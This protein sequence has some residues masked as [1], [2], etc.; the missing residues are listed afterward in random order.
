MTDA[1]PQ[2]SPANGS[3]GQGAV[4]LS[5]LPAGP[6]ERRLALGVALAS[7]AFFLLVAPFAR[8]QLGQVWA[9]IPMYESAAAMCDLITAALLLGQFGLLR[10]RAL[11]VL[12]CAYLYTALMTVPHLLTFPGL[13]A[14]AGLLG[15][16]LQSTAWLYIFWHSG[17]PLLVAAY[18][19]LG[20]PGQA[21]PIAGRSAPALLGGLAVVA[22]AVG[23][24]VL[25]A[26][27]G[28]GVLPLL[29]QGQGYT[30]QAVF[31]F[32]GM[33]A[34]GLLALVLLW[35]R[36]PFAVLDLWLT[37]V[38][39]AWLLEVALSAVINGGRFSL[40]FYAG[41]AY[42]LLAAGF[43]LIVLLVEHGRLYARLLWAYEAE[44]RER[45]LVQ[46]KSTELKQLNRDLDAF[47]YSVSHD[48]RA[49]RCA[50]STASR[51]YSRKTTAIGSMPKGAAC[52][53]CCATAAAA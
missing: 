43:L 7:A 23:A 38:V 24:G 6:G 36:R 37:V 14:P 20:K 8:I 48:L 46:E 16:G 52:S 39:L 28:H 45:R 11:L 31:V 27:A 29:M 44:R 13:F 2:T 34:V 49:R 18:A 4:F 33:W 32:S 40:G 19:L 35:R 42:G 10:S 26:T 5:T 25:L 21:A 17:F 15:A 30:P 22:A 12:G 47:S 41:R 3:N 50:R 1:T 9:F 53:A 51:A